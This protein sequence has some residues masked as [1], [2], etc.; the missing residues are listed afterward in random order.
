VATPL[1]YRHKTFQPLTCQILVACQQ[2]LPYLTKPA[3]GQCDDAVSVTFKPVD[4]YMCTFRVLTFLI[5][6]GDKLGKV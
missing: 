2:G 1:V 5:T 4:F 6:S 3:T